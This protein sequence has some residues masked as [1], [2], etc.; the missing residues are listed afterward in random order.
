MNKS[1]SKLIRKFVAPEDN[2]VAKKVYR[3]MKKGYNKL[4]AEQKFLFKKEIRQILS[5]R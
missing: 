4:D 1:S 3:R 5:R 2:P